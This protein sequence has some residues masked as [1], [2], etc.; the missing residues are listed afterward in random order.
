MMAA[1]A[2][3]HN[4]SLYQDKDKENENFS[5]KL[6]MD[7]IEKKFD[8]RYKKI[9][10]FIKGFGIQYFVKCVQPTSVMR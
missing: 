2:L 10:K 5:H 1:Q 9:T 7:K 8:L 3:E 4:Q 6:S